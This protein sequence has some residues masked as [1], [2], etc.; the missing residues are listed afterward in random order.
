MSG[1]PAHPVTRFMALVDQASIRRDG[2]WVWRGG[3]KGNGYGSFVLNGKSTPAHRAAFILF[4]DASPEGKDVCHRCDNRA[5]VN[6]DHLFLGTR[7]ENMQD[8]KRKGRTARGAKLGDRRGA[9]GPAAKLSW[10]DVRKIRASREPSPVLAARHG[11]CASN[12]DRIRRH[13]TWKEA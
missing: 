2:C 10:D 12:I 4:N 1:A 8:C 11:V 5:C 7:L 3:G 6:P 13:D 9:S